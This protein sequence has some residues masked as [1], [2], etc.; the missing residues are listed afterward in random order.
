MEAYFRFGVFKA[1]T[2]LNMEFHSINLR[3]HAVDKH[4][5]IDDSPFGGGDGMV[6]RVEPLA[7]AVRALPKPGR[8]IYTSPSGRL[9]TQKDAERYAALDEDLIFICG[10]FAGIDQRFVDEFVAD[11]VSIGDFVVSGGELPSLLI[12]DSILRQ[13]PGVLGNERSAPAAACRACLNILFIRARWNSKGTRCL[14]CFY[15]A[16]IRKSKPGAMPRPSRRPGNF[17]LIF[18]RVNPKDSELAKAAPQ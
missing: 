5:S 13:I 16:I 4:G 1:A 6:M 12:A 17:G 2:R 8:V 15:R 9:W 18:S 11:E 10:R 14:M 3:T 7:A